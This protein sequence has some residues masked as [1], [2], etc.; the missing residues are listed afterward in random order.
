MPPNHRRWWDRQ[1]R[2][3]CRIAVPGTA[4][5]FVGFCLITGCPITLWQTLTAF[6]LM[7]ALFGAVLC[8]ILPLPR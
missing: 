7:G 4:I 5:A 1:H 3:D 2:Q 6:A 8:Y